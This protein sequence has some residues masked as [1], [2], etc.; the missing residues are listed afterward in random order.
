MKES[1]QEDFINEV[2]IM[3]RLRHPNIVNFLGVCSLVRSLT[4]LSR[5]A[6]VCLFDT[7]NSTHTCTGHRAD[8]QSIHASATCSPPVMYNHQQQEPNRCIVTE[9]MHNGSLEDFALGRVKEGKKLSLT[10]IIDMSLD[11]AKGLN[12]LHHKSIIH[13]DMK[14]ANVLVGRSGACKIADFGLAHIK[15]RKASTTGFY[16]DVGTPCYMAP[17]VLENARYNM[18]CDVFSFGMV[19][20]ELCVGHYPFAKMPGYKKMKTCDFEKLIT[21]AVRPPIPE[22]IDA[23]VRTLIQQCWAHSPKDRPTMNQAMKTLME[24]KESRKNI[25]RD[26]LDDL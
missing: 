17:E 15:S 16:G 26:V 21:D 6:T 3:K 8:A 12:W 11:I 23:S 18:S 13:R 5:P 7:F 20:C 24:I 2:R 4:A 25:P 14:T 19:L 22:E 10:A 1:D 9:F